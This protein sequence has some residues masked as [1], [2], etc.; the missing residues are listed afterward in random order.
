MQAN[1]KRE[2]ANSNHDLEEGAYLHVQ[3]GS[4]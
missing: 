1:L 2:V 3:K 4:T